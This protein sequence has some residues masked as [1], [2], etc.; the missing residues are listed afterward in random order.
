VVYTVAID[1]DLDVILKQFQ[2][3]LKEGEEIVSMA[4]HENKL[5]ITTKEAKTNNKHLLLG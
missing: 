1:S 5:I 3:Q 2:Q 4:I